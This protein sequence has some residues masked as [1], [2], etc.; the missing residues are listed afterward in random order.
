VQVAGAQYKAIEFTGS[1][2]TNMNMEERMTL[3]NMAIEAGGKNGIIAPDETTFEYIRERR[4][5]YQYEPVYSSPDAHYEA[6]YSVDVANLDPT[7]AAPH[8]PDNRKKAKECSDVP[9]DRAYIGSCT[10]VCQPACCAALSCAGVP[11]CTLRLS[12]QPRDGHGMHVAAALHPLHQATLLH[13]IATALHAP[14]CSATP[15]CM[16]SMLCI[17]QLLLDALG[18]ATCLP[19][20]TCMCTAVRGS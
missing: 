6:E 16:H 20:R 10:G 4:P 12:G 3:C 18:S 14:H 1:T 2:L 19:F 8:S 9:I 5:D 13:R 11:A 7:V 17:V 15:R